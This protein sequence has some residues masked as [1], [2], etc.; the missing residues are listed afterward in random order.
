[1]SVHSY[2]TTNIAFSSFDTWSTQYS[3]DA[4]VAL[5][6]VLDNIEPAAGSYSINTEM[7]SNAFLY[8]ACTR[9]GAAG[10]V[11]VHAGYT[12]GA[13]QSFT[14]K[15]V[16]FNDVA[17]V[18]LRVTATYPNY[19][20]GWYTAASKGGTQLVNGGTS[21]TQLDIDLTSTTHTSVGNFYGYIE[22]GTTY[23]SI[24]LGYGDYGNPSYACD[25]YNC[26]ATITQYTT[27]DP[28]SDF[29]Q[30]GEQL[31]ST[32][33]G[34]SP[35]TQGYYSDGTRARYWTG[36]AWNGTTTICSPC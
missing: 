32:S 6:T 33:N 8:G 9:D 28:T 31:S 23:S 34:S 25:E 21:T 13:A 18:T 19:I 14:L 1:M 30:D 12:Q 3:S 20:A 27:A 10:N 15:N 5:K 7:K 22:Q 16:S 29:Y 24:T 17:T 36:T 11:R 35:S 2:G 26:G 4:N